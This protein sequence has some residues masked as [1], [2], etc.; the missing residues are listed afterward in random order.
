MGDMY[1]HWSS[2]ASEQANGNDSVYKTLISK[3]K[4]SISISSNDEGLARQAINGEAPSENHPREDNTF[5]RFPPKHVDLVSDV[6]TQ[7]L[8]ITN[9]SNA[10]IETEIATSIKARVDILI[11]KIEKKLLGV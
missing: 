2:R 9:L 4:I 10:N 1:Y 8:D 5:D 7:S 3:N 6:I 11:K